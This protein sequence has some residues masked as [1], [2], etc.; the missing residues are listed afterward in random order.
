[1]WYDV[2]IK[3]WLKI[4]KIE[5]YYYVYSTELSELYSYT[6]DYVSFNAYS[7][8]WKPS[9]RASEQEVYKNSDKLWHIHMVTFVFYV[10]YEH[11]TTEEEKKT[12][13]TEHTSTYSIELL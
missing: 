8:N 10:V 13:R 2:T 4:L 6:G 3:I 12:L 1:M 7:T 5:N 9:E 11:E